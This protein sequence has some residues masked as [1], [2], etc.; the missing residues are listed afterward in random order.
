MTPQAPEKPLTYSQMQVLKAIVRKE[1]FTTLAKPGTWYQ[2]EGRYSHVVT[3]TMRALIVRGLVT[4]DQAFTDTRR[5]ARL[6]QAGYAALSRAT[7][8]PPAKKRS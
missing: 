5:G 8:H 3:S 7:R 4:P 6:T 2:G 1:V